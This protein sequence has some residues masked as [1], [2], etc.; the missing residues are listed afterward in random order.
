M[1]I[2]ASDTESAAEREI[3]LTLSLFYTLLYSNLSFSVQ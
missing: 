2:S 3:L 1:G